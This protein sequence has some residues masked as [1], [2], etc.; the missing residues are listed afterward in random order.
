[1]FSSVN[2]SRSGLDWHDLDLIS[3]H[4]LGHKRRLV[5]DEACFEL[6]DALAA[7]LKA[8]LHGHILSILVVKYGVD[9]VASVSV[10]SLCYLLQGAKVV[11][12]VELRLLLNFIKASH[13]HVDLEGAARAE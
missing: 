12:P 7:S 10:G 6:L 4:N 11:H 1:M 3:S 2:R 9:E 8:L 13:K 5:D